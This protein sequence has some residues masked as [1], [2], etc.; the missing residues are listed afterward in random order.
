MSPRPKARTN[1]SKTGMG[2]MQA[3]DPRLLVI[4]GAAEDLGILPASVALG[5]STTLV[6]RA[7]RIHGVKSRPLGWH[8]LS[9]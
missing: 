3:H 4:A 6:R 9:K 7:M 1:R 2:R 5:I 8:L